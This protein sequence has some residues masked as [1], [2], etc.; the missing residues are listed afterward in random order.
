MEILHKP[1]S[2]WYISL[3]PRVSDFSNATSFFSGLITK[4]QNII[5]L[6]SLEKNMKNLQTKNKTKNLRHSC[7]DKQWSQI[8]AKFQNN[9]MTCKRNG[10]QKWSKILQSSLLQA[11]LH[12]VTWHFITKDVLVIAPQVDGWWWH[13]SLNNIKIDLIFL[14]EPSN[15]ASTKQKCFCHNTLL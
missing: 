5:C 2:H 9:L 6:T 15:N 14:V 7:R 10:V 4:Y 8:L 3:Q 12:G 1:L 11:E 13:T